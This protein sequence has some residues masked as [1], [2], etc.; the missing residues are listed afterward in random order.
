[1]ITMDIE[2]FSRLEDYYRKDSGGQKWKEILNDS[3][4]LVTL[5]KRGSLDK[6]QP[7][8]RRETHDYFDVLKRT[9]VLMKVRQLSLYPA[10][11]IRDVWR[12]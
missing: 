10:T 7:P 2:D 11:F 8:N 1:M 4:K 12:L 6:L 5:A 3:Y 9:V